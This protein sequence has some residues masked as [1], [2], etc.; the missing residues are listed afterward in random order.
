[1]GWFDPVYPF[2]EQLEAVK[3]RRYLA[4]FMAS[5]SGYCKLAVKRLYKAMSIA[6]S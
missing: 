1:M 2:P 6:N 3:S 5:I 4:T